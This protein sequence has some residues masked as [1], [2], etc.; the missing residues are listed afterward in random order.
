M[1]KMAAIPINCKNRKKLSLEPMD[2]F[3]QNLVCRIRDAEKLLLG[4][5]L[6]YF[7]DEVKFGH[8]CFSIDKSENRIFQE[9]C[10]LGPERR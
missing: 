3:Q 9:F 4:L 8:T 5:T 7:K 10:H 6:S 1:T 2:R